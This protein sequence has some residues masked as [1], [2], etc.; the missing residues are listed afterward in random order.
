MNHAFSE[1][2]PTFEFHP[3]ICILVELNKASLETRFCENGSLSMGRNVG[4]DV[5]IK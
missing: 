2:T 3:V 1:K 5:K 4:N